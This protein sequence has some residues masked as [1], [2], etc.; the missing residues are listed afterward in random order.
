MPA[1]TLNGGA[2]VPG[3]LIYRFDAS[4]LFFNADYFKER[5]RKV[6]AEAAA[7]PRWLLLDATSILVLDIT[8]SQALE[9]IRAELAAKGT[10]LAVARA[11]GFFRVM[12]DRS[13]L[14]ERIGREHLF[15]TVHEGAAAFASK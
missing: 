13:G 10:V 1:P 2:R 8:G 11:K 15:S 7:P 4:L 3:L 9:A 5:V 12:L 14:A 6:V